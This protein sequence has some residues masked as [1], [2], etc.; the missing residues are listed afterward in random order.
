MDKIYE[1]F[2]KLESYVTANYDNPIFWLGV[3]A[4]IILVMFP[5][6]SSFSNK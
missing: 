3:V 2:D 6:I 5:A 4:V 1:I